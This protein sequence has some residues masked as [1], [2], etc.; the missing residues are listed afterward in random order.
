MGSRLS[1]NLSDGNP[2]LILSYFTIKSTDNPYSVLK[3][4]GSIEHTEPTL[5]RPWELKIYFTWNSRLKSIESTL[6]SK[7]C[8][9][10][11]D[12]LCFLA[13]GFYALQFRIPCEIYFEPLM[14]TISSWICFI[15]VLF[16]SFKILSAYCG[17]KQ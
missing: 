15:D 16:I 11:L 14:Y 9:I 5:I 13:G 10:R 3:S 1:W 17:E 8:T 6:L 4:M 2:F 12:W 7:F